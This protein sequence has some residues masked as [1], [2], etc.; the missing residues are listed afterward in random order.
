MRRMYSLKQLKAI[1]NAQAQQLIESGLVENAKPLYF[2]P[3]TL[4]QSGNSTI[5]WF[6]CLIILNNSAEPID[7]FDK[8]KAEFD[9]IFDSLPEGI[10]YA[11]FP[12]TGTFSNADSWAILGAIEVTG[13]DDDK[14]KFTGRNGSSNNTINLA[15]STMDYPARVFDGVN[16]IN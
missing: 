11:R 1:A 6:C 2:H 10:N 9:R 15:F 12:C 16:K 3:I 13:K 5:Q 4:L 7:S 14:R 8:L